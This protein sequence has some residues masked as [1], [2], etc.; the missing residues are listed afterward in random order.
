MAADILVYKRDARAGRRGPE[1]A[2]RT[3]PRHRAEVQQR[4]RGGDRGEAGSGT[5][6][7]VLPAARADDPGAGAAGDEPARRHQEDVEVRSVGLFAHQPDRRCR[8]DRPEVP[9]GEDRSRTAALARRRAWSGRPEADN[10]VGIYAGARGDQGS[11]CSPSSAADSSPTFKAALADLAVS[12][13]RA[14]RRRRCAACSPIPPRSTAC[15]ATAPSG[16]RAIAEPIMR[17]VK[18]IVG[19]IV[20]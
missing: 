8:H 4:L 3:G 17:D 19:F 20:S 6:G 16:P 9:Q 7:S 10:L 13:A 5:D 2:S 1:A 18:D 15:S 14:D 12:Q 11:R